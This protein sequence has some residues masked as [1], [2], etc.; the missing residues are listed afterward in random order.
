M[1]ILIFGAAGQLGF[2]LCEQLKGKHEVFGL[3]RLEADITQLG[4][5]LE[6]AK[7]FS[8]DVIINAA[9]YTDVDGC[10]NNKDQAFLVNAIGARNVAI[11]S[12]EVGAKLVH[13]STDYVFD[14]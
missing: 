10:E 6:K 14:G 11:A 8:P 9:A 2:E 4:Q 12:R 7:N 3:S 5:V 1:R 13:I